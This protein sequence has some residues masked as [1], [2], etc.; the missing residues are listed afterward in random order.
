MARSLP[1][2]IFASCVC[3]GMFA[4]VFSAQ[5]ALPDAMVSSVLIGESR[6][7]LVMDGEP[8]GAPREDLVAWVR[9]AAESIVAYYG[10]YP[11][12]HLSI[13]I[14]AYEGRGI[15]GGRTYVRDGGSIMIRVGEETTSAEFNSYWIMTHEML[16]LTFP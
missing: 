10:R 3:L 12:P 7:D 4:P 15:R 16:H 9:A 6:I 14:R 8:A 11:L 5:K 2:L 1:V 13:H